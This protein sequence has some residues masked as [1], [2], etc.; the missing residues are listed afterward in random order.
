[1]NIKVALGLVSALLLVLIAFGLKFN[2][3]LGNVIPDRIV[4]DFRDKTQSRSPEEIFL[5]CNL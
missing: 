5:T 3:I 4:S 2:K 1:M